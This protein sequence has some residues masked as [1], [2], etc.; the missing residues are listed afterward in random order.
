MCAKDIVVNSHIIAISEPE[1]R[2]SF[3]HSH[4]Q[5]NTIIVSLVDLRLFPSTSNYSQFSFSGKYRKAQK[6]VKENASNCSRQTF[7]VL[8][9]TMKIFLAPRVCW[10]NLIT[11]SIWKRLLFSLFY[12]NALFVWQKIWFLLHNWNNWCINTVNI[13][14]DRHKVAQFF[15][16]NLVTSFQVLFLLSVREGSE[17]KKEWK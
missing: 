16:Q 7:I 2:Q 3:S 12:R 4:T 5:T 11:Y 8:T 13:T 14:I 17:I 9:N 6:A 15:A 10:Y 1:W